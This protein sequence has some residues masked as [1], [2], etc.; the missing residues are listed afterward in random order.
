MAAMGTA[1]HA[2]VEHQGE[3]FRIASRQARG[4]TAPYLVINKKGK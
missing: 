4:L 2:Y 1:K 3:K